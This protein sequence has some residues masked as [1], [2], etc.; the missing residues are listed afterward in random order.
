M[1]NKNGVSKEEAIFIIDK[2][3]IKGVIPTSLLS[4]IKLKQF[5]DI[6]VK[7]FAYILPRN[8]IL[9]FIYKLIRF[10]FPVDCFITNWAKNWKCEW[11]ILKDKYQLCGFKSRSEAIYYELKLAELNLL[12][13]NRE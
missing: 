4:D 10:I 9:R 8:K 6:S 1:G 3:E 12:R 7:R 13:R 2:N 11:V 5:G